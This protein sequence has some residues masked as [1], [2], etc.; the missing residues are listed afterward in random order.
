MEHQLIYYEDG[1]SSSDMFLTVPL[2]ARKNGLFFSSPSSQ[3]ARIEST[4]GRS[5]L[6]PYI[7][8]FRDERFSILDSQPA[9][10]LPGEWVIFKH[11]PPLD[12]KIIIVNNHIEIS[13]NYYCL[14]LFF[15]LA[16]IHIKK[17]INFNLRI[18]KFGKTYHA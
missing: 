13:T 4:P 18:F 2:Q 5:K 16:T 3:T 1:H 10:W 14:D 6:C 11:L 15:S 17:R 12:N 7:R 8:I 9:Y